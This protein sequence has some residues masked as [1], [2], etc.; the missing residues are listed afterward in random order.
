MAIFNREDDT[1][2]VVKAAE[3]NASLPSCV[4]EIGGLVELEKVFR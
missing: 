3:R 4:E 2:A 1:R